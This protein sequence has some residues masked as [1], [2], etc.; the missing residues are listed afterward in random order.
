MTAPLRLAAAG[1]ADLEGLLGTSGYARAWRDIPLDPLRDKLRWRALFES[2]FPG[3]RHLDRLSRIACAATECAGLPARAAPADDTTAVVAIGAAG[4]LDAD[5]HFEA[6]L[7]SSHGTQAGLFP[8]T[9][10]STFLGVL[11]LRYGLTGPTLA[12]ST[13]PGGEAPALGEALGLVQEGLA[14]RVLVC[15]GDWVGVEAGAS[16][17]DLGLEASARLVVLLIE[18]GDALESDLAP[19]DALLEARDPAGLALQQL[20]RAHAD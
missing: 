13:P 18:P 4:C 20:R 17:A 10:P 15:L 16:A 19:V 6:S 12:Y 3:A 11:A 2:S 8:Y 9:L 7:G 1:G 5:W 14:G